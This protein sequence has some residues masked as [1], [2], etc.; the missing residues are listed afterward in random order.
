MTGALD[1]ILSDPEVQT[2]VWL[3][4]LYAVASLVAPVTKRVYKAGCRYLSSAQ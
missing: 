3:L 1:T 2:S 4:F